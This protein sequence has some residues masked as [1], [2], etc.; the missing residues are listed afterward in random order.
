M[1]LLTAHLENFRSTEN[2]TLDFSGQGMHALIGPPG[3]GKSSVF[4]GLVFAMFG[5]PGPDQELLDLRY[6]RAPDGEDV[7]ADYT[8]SHDGAIYRTLRTLR[9]GKR[10]GQPVEKASAQMWRDGVEIDNMTPTLM[11]SQVT[12]I[13]GMGE[14][15]LTGSS[16]IR[17]GEVDVL[18][19]A[20]PTE[21]QRLVEEHTGISALT[22]A[23]DAA[24]KEANEARKVS[25]AL[26]GSPAEMT[27]A[28]EA[29][30]EAQA[31][32][33][34][35]DAAA[36]GARANADRA[37][38]NWKDAQQCANELQ[39][40]AN[41]AQAAREAV[42]AAQAALQSA[43]TAEH[44]AKAVAAEI[45]VDV[46]A[47]T[48]DVD[49][50]WQKLSQRRDQIADCGNTLLGANKAAA[51]AAQAVDAKT[52]EL[53]E[54]TGA[55]GE[56]GERRD[57]LAAAIADTTEA[58]H[59]ARSEQ[60]SAAG[61]VGRLSKA[62]AALTEL[63][64]DA[65]CPTCQHTL[66]DTTALVDD[67]REQLAAAQS[68]ADAAGAAIGELTATVG[69]LNA[70]ARQV[71]AELSRIDVL[72]ADRDRA[73]ARAAD[74][75]ADLVAALEA[76]A[77]HLPEP[78]GGYTDTV[79]ALRGVKDGI[80]QTLSRVGEQRAAVRQLAQA[81]TVVADCRTKLA[82][83]QAGVVDAPDPKDIA[84]ALNDAGQL[85]SV[86]EALR[87]EA[88]AAGAVAQTALLGASQLRSTAEVAANQ[89]NRKQAAVTAA[90]VADTT[91]QVLA[92]Y[93]QDL[94]GDFCDGISAAATELL[95]RFGGEHVAFRLDSEFVPRVE[96]ADGRLR[97]TSS[98]SGG[99]KA[100]AGLAFRL[101]ISM[102]ITA[103]TM[104]D[105]LIGDEI[106]SYLDEDGRRQIL[107]VIS[108][109][110]DA[111]ILVSHTSE[112]LDHASQVHELWRSPLG[113]T[114]MIDRDLAS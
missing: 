41:A 14:R 33:D 110:F 74:A 48:G 79:A 92:A 32:A 49:A 114:E 93:R 80:D 16:L 13:L 12:S 109:L 47:D 89:W 10:K 42:V 68:S 60:A 24:R 75:Q 86:A 55:A 21:V 87:A 20:P 111:P 18:T 104:P 69:D 26:P 61:E 17:Q 73:A 83:A 35:L 52:A 39:Q 5:S 91:A 44:G 50:Q 11:T 36:T 22:K 107:D 38:Q 96:L 88:D 30:E 100:R 67:L 66:D 51:A 94:I 95:A 29:A 19:T 57:Q 56:L 1:R 78:A 108:A 82:T 9:R 76:C 45:G 23:R 112:I 46:D 3:S 28:A 97:K 27:E 40:A 99:E 2:L 77:A 64:G 15:G 62:I 105:Q 65:H 54:V 53:A 90:E 63:D 98:L 6:D 43:E 31:E 101:G 58:G 59:R 71:A 84:A 4:G 34:A 81:R 113:T 7:V 103:E 25:D 106:T 102:Q 85:Q 8:W 70:Q 37:Q 72:T